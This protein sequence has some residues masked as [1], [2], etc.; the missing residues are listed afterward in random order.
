MKQFDQQLN[1]LRTP[2]VLR[3]AL[4]A[5]MVQVLLPQPADLDLLTSIGMKDYVDEIQALHMPGIKVRS[6]R[7][8]EHLENPKLLLAGL[9]PS[10]KHL[11]NLQCN[12]RRQ[13]RR[14]DGQPVFKVHKKLQAQQGS[15]IVHQR[16]RN[17][18]VQAAAT[19]A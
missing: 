1:P 12:Q 3:V 17:V 11:R 8:H 2:G 15:V 5:K 19:A 9:L 14:N 10:G 7:G 13:K 6:T 4:V 16:Q 18:H